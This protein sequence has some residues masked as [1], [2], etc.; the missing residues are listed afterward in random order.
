MFGPDNNSAV[1]VR[2]TPAAPGTMGWFSSGNPATGTLPTLVEADF[3]NGIV[4]E[5]LS[6]L[7]QAGITPSK[8]SVGQL[9]QAIQIVAKQVGD[10]LYLPIG[11]DRVTHSELASAIATAITNLVNGSPAV[12]D[13]LKELSDALGADP[14]FATTMANALALKAPLLSPGLT[15][16]P[17]APTQGKTDNSTKLATTSFVKSVGLIAA[18]FA[19]SG[20]STLTLT[21]AQAG[22]VLSNY[23][24]G[25]VWTLPSIA[26]C[27]AHAVFTIYASAK[28]TVQRAGSDVIVSNGGGGASVELA[29]GQTLMVAAEPGYWRPLVDPYGTRRQRLIS[30]TVISTPVAQVDFTWTAGQFTQ[31]YLSVVGGSAAVKLRDASGSWSSTVANTGGVD[32]YHSFLYAE[33][34]RGQVL[35]AGSNPVSSPS[36]SFDTGYSAVRGTVHTGGLSGLRCDTNGGGNLTA[37]TFQLYGF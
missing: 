16:A 5:V 31:L 11:A 18:A 23:Y 34:D 30:Q 35:T 19:E 3:L 32:S 17:T 24:A 22:Q 25:A 29:P 8:A 9:L 36:F 4:A 26:S 6:V 7:T 20:T 15:G 28:M 10:P 14:N 33:R 13:T 12:L 21:A 37:G 27:E 1:A 2:P